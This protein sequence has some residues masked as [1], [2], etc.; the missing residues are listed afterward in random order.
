MQPWRRILALKLELQALH[1]P[2]N[3]QGPLG[4]DSQDLACLRAVAA[5]SR[6]AFTE[7]YRRHHPRLAR[8]LLRFTQ[9]RDLVDD[10]INDAM[11]IVWRKAA[12]FRGDAK[13]STWVTGVAYR[14][15][16]KALREK[17]Y[18][19]EVSESS[20][21]GL[22]L[23]D[24]GG[25]APSEQGDRELRDWIAQG[26][27]QLPDDQRVT[28]ELAYFMG[29]SCE[30]IATIMGC[31]V[32]T[33]KSRLFHARVRLRNVLPQLGGEAAPKDEPGVA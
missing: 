33:V 21:E 11:W 15:M 27:K 19:D 13:V 9:R 7:L 29:E 25:A 30:D 8:F 12:D 2:P 31:A 32:G 18:A 14:C 17:L 5:G 3:N 6:E 10:V 20:L 24:L 1:I 22:S 28:L 16:L 26:L 23:E 4:P